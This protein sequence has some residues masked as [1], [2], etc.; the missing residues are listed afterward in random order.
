MVVGE[1]D[2]DHDELL[3][4]AT[5][6]AGGAGGAGSRTVTV[7]PSPGVLRIRAVPPTSVARARSPAR[8]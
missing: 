7:V 4:G 6:D 1:D 3:N 2:P 8:P 5:G